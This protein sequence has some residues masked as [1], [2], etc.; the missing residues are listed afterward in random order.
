[1]KKKLY[2]LILCTFLLPLTPVYAVP[3]LGT[4]SYWHA[5]QDGSEYGA[6][7]RWLNAPNTKHY[8]L[9]GFS[10]NTAF[11]SH[12]N[13]ARNAW[14]GAGISINS[15]SSDTTANFKIYGG[16][17][18]DISNYQ[19]GL[20]P[21]HHGYCNFNDS[22]LEGIWTYGTKQKYGLLQNSTNVYIIYKG[23]LGDQHYNNITLHEMAH[24]LGWRAHSTN[25]SDVMYG[26]TNLS[27]TT[28]TTRDK[29][30]IK[31]IYP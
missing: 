31:Q 13:F 26:F 28:L 14:R 24:G 20:T 11:L 29:E 7:A 25:S 15:T 2:I 16:N 9:S 6:I 27:P 4:L 17:L 5:H 8:Y 23:N 19:A 1:M 18:A 22:T 30:H 10:S 12:V 21:S 3:N